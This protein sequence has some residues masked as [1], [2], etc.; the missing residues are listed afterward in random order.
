MLLEVLAK[1]EVLATAQA[2]VL[3]RRLV[4]GFVASQ[5]ESGREGLVT[6]GVGLASEGFFHS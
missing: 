4:G 1:S 5:G 6:L 3:L 2:C